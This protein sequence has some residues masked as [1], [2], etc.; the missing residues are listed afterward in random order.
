M[1]HILGNRY[2]LYRGLFVLLSFCAGSFLLT[3]FSLFR[4]AESFNTAFLPVK[5]RAR[6]WFYF[7]KSTI[8][9]ICIAHIAM[10]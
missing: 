8:V 9:R 7:A 2:T 3:E 10:P 6:L 5:T 1:V 4:T